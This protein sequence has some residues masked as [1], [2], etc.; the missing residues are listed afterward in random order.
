MF[1]PATGL[2]YT[3]P[4]RHVWELAEGTLAA[5]LALGGHLWADVYPFLT[6]TATLCGF[7]L[8]VHGVWRLLRGQPTHTHPPEI[9]DVNQHD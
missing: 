3:G 8:A 5:M 7:I 4:M 9:H 1:D 2:P 6:G